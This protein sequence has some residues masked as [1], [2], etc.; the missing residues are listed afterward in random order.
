MPGLKSETVL[1]LPPGEA[2]QL[3]FLTGLGH[4]HILLGLEILPIGVRTGVDFIVIMGV[5][6]DG[7]AMAR[8]VFLTN[9]VLIVGKGMGGEEG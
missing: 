1:E 2:N 5:A 7:Y 8:R 3:G 6:V 4:D 9:H